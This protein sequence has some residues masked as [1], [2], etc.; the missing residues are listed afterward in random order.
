VS[1]S[2]SSRALSPEKEFL[3]LISIFTDTYTANCDEPEFRASLD[4]PTMRIFL[5]IFLFFFRKNFADHSFDKS[6]VSPVISVA[7]TEDRPSLC[8]TRHVNS[9]QRREIAGKGPWVV[10]ELPL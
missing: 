3:S 10:A 9:P 8:I 7:G 1:L 6:A 5:S 4:H 2:Q